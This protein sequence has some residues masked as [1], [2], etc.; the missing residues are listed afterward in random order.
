MLGTGQMNR[1]RVGDF[2][3]D[4]ILQRED[5]GEIFL[6]PLGPQLPAARH[7]DQTRGDSQ[8]IAIPLDRAPEHRRDA[9]LPGRRECILV[10]TTVASDRTERLH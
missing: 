5:V 8:T 9:E 7:F 4:C 1:Q 6:K 10:G 3:G 2:G